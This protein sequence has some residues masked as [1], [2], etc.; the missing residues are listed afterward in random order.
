MSITTLQVEEIGVSEVIT[1]LETIRVS[2]ILSG[3]ESVSISEIGFSGIK[4]E[5]G[6]SGSIG[7][8]DSTDGG[9]VYTTLTGAVDG[10]NKDFTVSEGE[11]ASG[12]LKVW[13]QGQLLSG[14]Y[15]SELIPSLGTFRITNP[16]NV[17]LDIMAEYVK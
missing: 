11:Y 8:I 5:T 13:K 12:K 6:A 3:A 9:G 17:G 1:E 16:P 10:V 15:W 14:S 7:Y 4:G 2:D